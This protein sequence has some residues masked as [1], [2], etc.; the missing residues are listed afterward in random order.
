M[1]ISLKEGR[2]HFCFSQ[3]ENFYKVLFFVGLNMHWNFFFLKETVIKRICDR[4]FSRF[5]DF[6]QKSKDAAFETLSDPKY[7]GKM[8][9]CILHSVCIQID[10]STLWVLS[11][12]CIKHA[13]SFSLLIYW[14]EE[15]FKCM[16]LSH[17]NRGKA[18]ISKLNLLP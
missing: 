5:P 3:I 17:M 18:S 13:S 9:V 4:V 12:S 14:A 16:L 6:V 2:L 8:K 1:L 15:H 10:Q 11:G 7:S